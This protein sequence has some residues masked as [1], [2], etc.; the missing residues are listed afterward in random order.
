MSDR[1]DTGGSRKRSVEDE[2]VVRELRAYQAAL[3]AGDEPDRARILALFPDLA[4]ELGGCLDGL[5]LMYHVAGRH[6]R[7]F[8]GEKLLGA[9]D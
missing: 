9:A 3:E 8:A 7:R 6:L 5:D 1:S 4:D 2:S